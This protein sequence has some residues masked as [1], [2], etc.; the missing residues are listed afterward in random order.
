M[1]TSTKEMEQNIMKKYKVKDLGIKR[2][3]NRMAQIVR[4]SDGQEML[5]G[6]KSTELEPTWLA[7]ANR[8][9]KEMNEGVGMGQYYIE[10]AE[11][12]QGGQK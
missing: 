12:V 8:L 2:G 4:I 10:K 3:N 11:K 6:F 1:I 9:V 5:Y 7:D